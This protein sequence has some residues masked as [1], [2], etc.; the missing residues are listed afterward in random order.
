LIARWGIVTVTLVPS[1]LKATAMNRRSWLTTLGGATLAVAW[2]R[3]AVA[4]EDKTQEEE[5]PLAK[6]PAVVRKAADKAVTGATWTTAYLVRDEEK[7]FYELEGKIAKGRVVIVTITPDGIAEDVTTEIPVK[8]VPESVMAALKA[9]Y[10]RFKSKV[11]FEISE[12]GK[13]T[14]YD[15]EGRRPK[16]K[17]DIG[18]YVSADGETIEIDEDE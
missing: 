11:A 18:I 3:P 15:F 10:P 9:K 14:G 1:L 8:E 17:H 16:D 7:S 2:S 4:D 13:V 5:I 12:D 6:V